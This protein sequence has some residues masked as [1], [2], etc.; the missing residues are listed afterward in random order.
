MKLINTGK[1]VCFYCGKRFNVS[2]IEEWIQDKKGDTAIC[3]Y[4][5][6][7]SVIPTLIDGEEITDEI[8]HEL[9]EYYFN[10]DVN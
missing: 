8:I 9:Y 7:D 6:I 4:C 10:A 1:C 5:D 3:P 2:E